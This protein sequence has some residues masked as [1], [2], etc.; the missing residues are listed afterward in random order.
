MT[1]NFIWVWQLVC[2]VHWILQLGIRI[3]KF[4]CRRTLAVSRG[5]EAKSAMQ[6]A[7]PAVS[8]LMVIGVSTS[9]AFMM[10]AATL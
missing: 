3:Q 7:V 2:H 9:A 1:K 4:T 6:A 10:V 5:K 8:S